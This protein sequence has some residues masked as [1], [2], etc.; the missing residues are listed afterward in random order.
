MTS[1]STHLPDLER[2]SSKA[3]AKNRNLLIAVALLIAGY[4]VLSFYQFDLGNIARK[5]NPDRASMFLLDTY[6]HKDHVTMRWTKP[7]EIVVAFE[8]GHRH[9]Y[10]PLPDWVTRLAD[11]GTEIAFENNGRMVIYD[12]RVE[13]PTWPGLDSPLVFRID[14]NKKPYV[15]GYQGSN[16]GLPSWI[17]VTENKVEVRP[18]LYERLQVYGSK[19]EIHRYEIGW[20]YFWFDFD[21]PLRDT[22]FLDAVKLAFSSDRVDPD[23]SN[24]RLVVHE[25]L[26]NSIW[27]HGVV[28]FAMLETVLMAVIGTMLACIVG[29][30][31]A[32]LAAANITPLRSIR[33][34]LRRVFDMLRGIDTLIWSLIFLRAFGPGLFT[35]IF[36]IAFTD[37]GTMGKLMSEAIENSESG[38]RE[39][40]RSTGASRI[41]QHR[42]GIL[43][44]ILP[45]FVSQALYYLESNTRSAVIVGAMGAGGIGLQFLGA[46]Q[47]GN[48]FENVAY[49]AALVLL[50]VIAM[51]NFSSW[52]RKLLIQYDAPESNNAAVQANP[53]Q[54]VAA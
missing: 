37:A 20:K 36:A 28:L 25:F 16:Q 8:G 14:E 27:F 11:S 19:V 51:D 42:F 34:A 52:L 26:D 10:D 31:L 22:G 47:T 46:L 49:M 6:A 21:S 48:D 35:G 2:L 1:Q 9:R 41:A 18:S 17:R 24:W 40:V 50:T 43:P 29:L 13:I 33:F 30:P 39:G 54:P 45:V 32:F 53:A 44:Q 38:Q 15:V 12:D 4:F 5:W 23:I 7:G 3:A